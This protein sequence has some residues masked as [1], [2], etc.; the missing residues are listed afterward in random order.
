MHTH[1]R[2]DSEPPGRYLG[3]SGPKLNLA[4]FHDISLCGAACRLFI[5]L[6]RPAS[7]KTASPGLF[8][9]PEAATEVTFLGGK[10]L[11]HV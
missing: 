4:Q 7:C 5:V 8:G 6:L 11:G 3:V 9:G 1:H 2:A 10:E